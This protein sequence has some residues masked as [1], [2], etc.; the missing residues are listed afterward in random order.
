VKTPHRR[1]VAL[2]VAAALTAPTLTA[3]S[4]NA[5]SSL[6]SG[7]A[8][9]TGSTLL[10]A[11]SIAAA[12]SSLRSDIHPGALPALLISALMGGLVGYLSFERFAFETSSK[13][14]SSGVDLADTFPDPD[15]PPAEF[16]S[17][18]NVRD[19]LWELTVYSPSMQR[20]ITND[21]VLP[22]GGPDNTA[23]RPTFYLLGGAGGGGWTG[24]G[25][26]PDFFRDKLI[27]VVTPRGAIGSQQ[28][29]WAQE[30]PKLGLYKWSTYLTK[31]LPPLID[32]H[33]HGTGN[34]AIAG[35]SMSGGP[36]LHIATLDDRFKVAGTY[37]SCQSTT[38]VLC[39]AFASSTVRFYGADPK[40]MWGSSADPAWAAHSP[41]LHLEDMR[42]LKL[43]AAASRG[44]P[45][46]TDQPVKDSPAPLLVVDEQFAYTCTRYFVDEARQAG[47]DVDFYEFD[48]GTHNW[49]LFRRQL[50]ET[51][52]TIGP[53]LGV[54]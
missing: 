29:D 32:A 14:G 38:G 3:P 47:L 21:L 16:V 26:A 15:A 27:N 37:S 1:G 20:N 52:K 9:E 40:N 4:A 41:V 50:P 49:G 22:E 28:A 18:E 25:G 36:A 23:P 31:E 24:D 54:G 44:V 30:D 35:M 19:N 8:V 43:F 33:F 34:D 6:S 17:L 11:S 12:F 5:S 39:Q 13:L 45:A 48:E 51:W 46:E 7:E 2:C 10:D 42:G 53:A